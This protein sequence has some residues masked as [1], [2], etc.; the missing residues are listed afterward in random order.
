VAKGNLDAFIRERWALDTAE[1]PPSANLSVDLTFRAERM[2]LLKILPLPPSTKEELKLFND[3]MRQN[4]E[5]NA[6]GTMRWRLSSLN[7]R[8]M[9]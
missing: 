5:P 3:L 4:L 2:M 6:R 7:S 1:E 9:K 8:Q